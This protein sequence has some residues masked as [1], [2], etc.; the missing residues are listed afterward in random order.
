VNYQPNNNL[1]DAPQ[2][3]VAPAEP[4]AGRPQLDAERLYEIEPGLFQ[5]SSLGAY[6]P[7]GVHVVVNVSDQPN[8]FLP[9][10]ELVAVLHMPLADHAFPGIDWLELA[11]DIITRFRRKNH[12]VVVHCDSAESRSTLVILGYFMRERAFN[13]EEALKDL[14]SKNPHADPNHR[15]LTGLEEYEK[16]LE[17]GA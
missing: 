16:K 2:P 3:A 10:H 12:T 1:P 14:Q 7:H 11:V 9:G 15:F 5:A 4:G 8:E 6:P 17:G 13:L